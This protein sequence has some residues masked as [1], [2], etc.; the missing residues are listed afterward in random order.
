MIW[1]VTKRMTRSRKRSFPSDRQMVV[2]GDKQST[3]LYLNAR[4]TK[5]IQAIASV[6]DF[7]CP[8]GRRVSR[9]GLWCCNMAWYATA[10]TVSL[11]SMKWTRLIL[12]CPERL[13]PLPSSSSQLS[14]VECFCT[15]DS[16]FLLS[17][18]V[19]Q[20]C[21]TE[22]HVTKSH[23]RQLCNIAGWL[24][25]CPHCQSSFWLDA[26]LASNLLQTLLRS[27]CS[28]TSPKHYC[29]KGW[30][31]ALRVSATCLSTSSISLT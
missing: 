2:R 22:W 4:P 19:M 21:V 29:V 16:I 14:Y 26:C 1:D 25:R 3:W 8:A 27:G 5:L 10:V 13:L 17:I 7:L 24:V 31:P 6:W 18:V 30:M 15:L 11:C 23:H 9:P 12:W 20:P 28:T